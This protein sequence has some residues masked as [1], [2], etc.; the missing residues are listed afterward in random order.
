[1]CKQ[2]SI[3]AKRLEAESKQIDL[4]NKV[5][6]QVRAG[7]NYQHFIGDKTDYDFETAEE[8]Y[9]KN[10]T[11]FNWLAITQTPYLCEEEFN[12]LANKLGINRS[13]EVVYITKN[14]TKPCSKCGK[15]CEENEW[16]ICGG[17]GTLFCIDCDKKENPH[18]SGKCNKCE[19][20]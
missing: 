5:V 13:Y 20:E 7:F 1:M 9:E 6:Y 17:C 3:I 16:F 2:R 18:A 19:K 8:I 12:D 10:K 14:D 15:D 4:L 11:I